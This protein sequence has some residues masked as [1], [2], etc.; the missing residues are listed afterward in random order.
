MAGTRWIASTSANAR[1]MRPVSA[2]FASTLTPH[3]V[4][5]RHPWPVLSL[6]SSPTRYP[7][8]KR[9]AK[10]SEN[11]SPCSFRSELWHKFV[12][13]KSDIEQARL[14]LE[15]SRA[16][17]E[18]KCQRLFVEFKKNGTWPVPTLTSKRMLGWLNN[19]QFRNYDRVR[20]F[21]WGGTRLADRE[22]RFSPERVD[23]RRLRRLAQSIR[24]RS[25]TGR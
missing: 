15:A 24:I 8:R 13:T 12:A 17:S 7:F 9:V 21:L 25:E 16:H 1:S 10:S 20:Y 6:S 14:T 2:K 22:R 19:A 3:T 5:M 4:C 18:E 23:G 11:S